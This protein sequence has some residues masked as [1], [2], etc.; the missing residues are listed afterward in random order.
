MWFRARVLGH[1]EC[2]PS[3][4]DSSGSVGRQGC[5]FLFDG[6]HVQYP[7]KVSYEHNSH[8]HGKVQV[9]HREVTVCIGAQIGISISG[10]ETAA[11]VDTVNPA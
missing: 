2:G 11:V 3:A 6:L 1:G 4:L 8:L 9:G 10:Q 7:D 5:Q